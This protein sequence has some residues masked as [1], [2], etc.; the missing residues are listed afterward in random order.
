[1][2]GA[3]EL[4]TALLFTY[5]CRQG[6]CCASNTR[7]SASP[8]TLP[9]MLNNDRATIKLTDMKPNFLD[10]IRQRLTARPTSQ[11]NEVLFFATA[12][13]LFFNFMATAHLAHC[14]L[15]DTQTNASQKSKSQISLPTG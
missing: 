4:Q 6:H 8:Q 7:T 11:R 14:L 2:R 5:F 10:N 15:P 13:F 3:V 9:A 12:H 1:M